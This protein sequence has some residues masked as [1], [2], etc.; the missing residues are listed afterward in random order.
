MVVADREKCQGTLSNGAAA[1]CSLDLPPRPFA[2]LTLILVL[3]PPQRA[4][5]IRA[6]TCPSR[7]F[8]FPARGGGLSPP[9]GSLGGKLLRFYLVIS[10][11]GS[12][13]SHDAIVSRARQKNLCKKDE[14]QI[15]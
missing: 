6:S 2:C 5:T 15:S 10:R 13:R 11:F 8:D 4:R 1:I 9:G 14:C 12:A 7:R 3:A